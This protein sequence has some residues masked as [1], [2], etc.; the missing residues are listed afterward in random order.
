VTRTSRLIC[1]RRMIRSCLVIAFSTIMTVH[2]S[3]VQTTP[4]FQGTV[5]NYGVGMNPDDGCRHP[6]NG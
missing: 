1:P 2:Q 5:N 6:S 4:G 3:K